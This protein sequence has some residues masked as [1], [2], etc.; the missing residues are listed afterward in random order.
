MFM[1]IV[2]VPPTR[3]STMTGVPTRSLI[4]C[5]IARVTLSTLPPAG[6]VTMMRS[7]RDG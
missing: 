4:F 2:P 5:A 3:L 7:G 6:T 1:A